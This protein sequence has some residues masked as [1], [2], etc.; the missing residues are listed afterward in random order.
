MAN[1]QADT[2][3][4]RVCAW[5]GDSPHMPEL[6]NKLA[7]LVMHRLKRKLLYQQLQRI[8]KICPV[9][10]ESKAGQMRAGVCCSVP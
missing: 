5:V 4:R 7:A 10:V 1:G 6:A 3:G 8:C 9:H 2:A